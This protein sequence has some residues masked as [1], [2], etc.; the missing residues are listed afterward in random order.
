MSQ[1]RGFNV[2]NME[3]EATKGQKAQTVSER[4]LVFAYLLLCYSRSVLEFDDCFVKSSL[5]FLHLLSVP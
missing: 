2:L 5:H 1:L 4:R 3:P